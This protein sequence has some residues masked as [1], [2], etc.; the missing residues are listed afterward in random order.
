MS[1]CINFCSYIYLP[2]NLSLTLTVLHINSSKSVLQFNMNTLR[3]SYH[4]IYLLFEIS[5]LLKTHNIKRVLKGCLKTCQCL[6]LSTVKWLGIEPGTHFYI[7]ESCLLCFQVIICT[8]RRLWCCP[9]TKRAS[10]PA[11]CAA[12]EK[13]SACG[14]I[15][16]CM[17]QGSDS[18]AFTFR[19]DKGTRTNYCGRAMESRASP[20]SERQWTTNMTNST[21]LVAWRCIIKLTFTQHY[22]Q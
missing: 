18:W 17:A 7:L 5:T 10:S 1:S 11:L 12:L 16:T 2:P 19:L 6:F 14:S 4:F 9:V 22:F 20:G 8:L 3:T 13:Y 21:R 15:T